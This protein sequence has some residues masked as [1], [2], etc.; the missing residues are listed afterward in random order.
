M[1][2]YQIAYDNDLYLIIEGEVTISIDVIEETR[3]CTLEHAAK[4]RQRRRR[5]MLKLYQGDIFGF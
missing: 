3:L 4:I 5:S 2:C 1:E